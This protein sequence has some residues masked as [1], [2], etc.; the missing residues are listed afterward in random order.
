MNAAEARAQI[1]DAINDIQEIKS[2]LLTE[3]QAA[4]NLNCTLS[5]LEDAMRTLQDDDE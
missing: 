4:D 1:R 2:G 5:H 3:S